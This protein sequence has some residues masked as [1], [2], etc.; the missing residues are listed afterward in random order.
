MTVRSNAT[1]AL[2]LEDEPLIA[3][4]IEDELETAG[5]EVAA[6]AS[7]DD[8]D[9]WLDANTPDV[10]V[11]DIMLRDGPACG[12]VNRLLASKV[13]FV[14]H[15]GDHPSMHEGTPYTHGIWVNKPSGPDELANAAW[16]LLAD[17]GLP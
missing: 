4:G 8:A 15:S 9:Q 10:V 17:Q 13:P 3:I 11:V 12:I 5:F 6:V 1:V 7:C 14:V 2:L 16:S